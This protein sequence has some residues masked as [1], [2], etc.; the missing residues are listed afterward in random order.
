MDPLGRGLTSAD[1]DAVRNLKSDY[2]RHLDAKRWA[3]LRSLFA[4]DSTF[5]GFPF[6]A[7][8]ADGFVAGVSAFLCDVESV[9]QGFMPRLVA[10]GDHSI[11][12]VWSMHDYLVWP[13]DSREYRGAKIP[14]LHGIRGYGLYEEEYRRVG[15]A[16]RI[17]RMRLVRT[18]VELL[19]S[20]PMFL[21]VRQF[22]LP[23][24]DWLQ[25]G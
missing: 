4:D 17:S 6:A 8:D 3:R 11:R 13:R 16:W 24:P 7:N 9:H 10:T 2:F 23:D 18:R 5:D 19:V 25:E 1:F 12:G 21:P 14:G 15:E 20:E 22:G